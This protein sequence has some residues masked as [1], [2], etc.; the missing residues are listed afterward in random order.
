MKKYVVRTSLEKQKLEITFRYLE[1][2]DIFASFQFLYRVSR[3]AIAVTE[4]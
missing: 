4:A 1:T 3:F 2:A